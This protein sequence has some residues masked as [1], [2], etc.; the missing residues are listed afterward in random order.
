V[1]AARLLVLATVAAVALLPARTAAAP[2]AAS[3]CDRP[4]IGFLGPLTGSAAF[5]GK[6]Q[7][8]FARYAAR[9]LGGGR[10]RIVEADTALDPA[11][12]TRAAR[13]LHR[14]RDV[15]AVVG[16]AASREV[17][18]AARVFRSRERLPFISASA[19]ASGLTNGSIPNFFRV[20]PNDA[21]QAPTIAA[22][23]LRRLEV[24]SVLVVDDRSG[25]SRLLADEVRKRLRAAGVRVARAS[26]D[27][28]QTEY[29]DVVE[30]VDENV[31]AVF[32]PWQ[33]AAS[34]QVFG[35]QLREH[36]KPVTIVGADAL[37]SG[38]FT[39]AGSYVATF[40]PDVRQIAGNA[41]LLAGY[42]GR[43]VSNFGPLAYVATQ[44]AVAAVEQAC[45][46]GQA[47]RAEVLRRLRATH[48]PKTLLGRE[49][50]FTAKGDVA[51][52]RFSIF[53]LG[54]RGKKTLVG[55][56]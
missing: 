28:K 3:R 15:L 5:I 8:G 30:R 26:V 46:D 49:L 40:A 45:A 25:Y 35:M 33:I 1:T 22:F 42:G 55:R 20:V 2:S 21:A 56:P 36:A 54:A 27:Q 16:P 51:D 10:I 31:D 6:E 18:A 48:L 43:F 14:R 34:A 24:R 37:D 47:T 13:T 29:G 44:A 41:E 23:L 52:A 39:I 19:L 4:R 50:E 9:R 38:D 11:R 12:A 7:L 53:K 17:L 32:L